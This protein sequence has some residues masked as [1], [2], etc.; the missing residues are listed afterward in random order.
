VLRTCST[1]RFVFGCEQGQ[2]FAEYALILSLVMLVAL[3]TF[4]EAAGQVVRLYD[5]VTA[6][7]P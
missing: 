2:T 7:L 6:V 3:A 1:L 5:S 4:T